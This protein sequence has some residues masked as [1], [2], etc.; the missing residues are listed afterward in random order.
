MPEEIT[1][2]AWL[3]G[4]NLVAAGCLS[5]PVIGAGVLEDGLCSLAA[6]NR[7]AGSCA[8]AAQ[9]LGRCNNVF[10][11][12]FFGNDRR[13][14]NILAL[15]ACHSCGAI[16]CLGLNGRGGGFRGPKQLL[17]ALSLWSTSKR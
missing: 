4:R 11:I 13:R 12:A 17:G 7:L 3:R 16:G 15:G 9:V 2:F 6:A 1:G 14:R 8:V 10:D 5:G